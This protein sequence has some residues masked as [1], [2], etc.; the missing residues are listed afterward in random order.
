MSIQ[1]KDL[2]EIASKSFDFMVKL[3]RDIGNLLLLIVLNLIPIVDFI[4]LGYFINVVRRDASEPPKLSN[5][6]GLFIEGLKLVI[7]ALIYFLIPLIILLVG[8][9]GAILSS[10]MRPF[11][12]F[13]GITFILI[14][15]AVLLLLLIL[16]FALPILGIYMRT[17]DF[18]KIFAFGE[19]WDLISRFGLGN[20]ILFFLLLAGFNAIAFSIGSLLSWVGI[21]IVGVFANAFTFKAVSLFVN[22]K[23][24][25]PP[26]PPP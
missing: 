17:G 19:S 16:F 6:G 24:P 5:F 14:V 12:I 22:I 1:T 15:V 26:P 9:G 23:Y 4:V 7:A 20:Y 2:S 3:T 21:A 8:V 18:A 13:R 25:L 11:F 10:F